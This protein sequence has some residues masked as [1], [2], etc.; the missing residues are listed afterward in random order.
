MHRIL[1]LLIC[2]LAI[3]SVRVEAQIDLLPL[4]TNSQV[5]AFL[6]RNPG[7]VWNKENSLYKW[8]QRDT[9]KIPFFD[10]FTSTTIYPDSSKWLDNQVFV[11][12]DF[13]IN[14]PSYGV[15]TFDFLT[16]EGVPYSPLED[17]EMM[18]ADSLTSQPINLKDSA[19]SSYG[20]ADSFFFS[21]Y[22][23]TRGYGD[24]ITEDDSLRLEFLDA[25]GDWN[26]VWSKGGD[27]IQPFRQVIFPLVDL[28]YYHQAFQFRFVNITHLWGNNNHWHLDYIYL[29]N[30][31][32]VGDT[33]FDDYAIQSRPTSLLKS[34][35]SM[36]Y[37]HFLADPSEAADSIFFNVSNRND[38]VI[39]AQIKHEEKHKGNTLVST[40]FS[41]N[42][43]N[44][45]NGGYAQRK[46]KNYDF[47]GL[48]GLPVIID[49]KYSIME[50]GRVNPVLFQGNDNIEVQQ[51][52]ERYYAYDDG[53]AESGF[54]FNDLRNGEGQIAISFDLKKS[55]SLQAIAMNLTYNINDLSKQ[56]FILTIWQDLGLGGG[57]PVILYEQQLVTDSLHLNPSINGYYLIG[58]TSPIYLSTGKFYVGWSQDRNY[59]LGVGFDK[60]NGYLPGSRTMNKNIYF[61]IGDGWVQNNNSSL[62]GAPMIRPIF[63]VKEPWNVGIKE[64]RNEV[65][66]VFPNPASSKLFISQEFF[67]YKVY[68]AQGQ[69]VE[70][71]INGPSE[72]DISSLANGVYIITMEFI[73]GHT[74]ALRFV[75]SN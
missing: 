15:A 36:P 49:R 31:R 41:D 30:H 19:G 12:T 28:S 48:S 20:P 47:S 58:L 54:G 38:I 62:V 26:L 56:R 50:S 52:F 59:N 46:V 22:Y 44:V 66:S 57:E 68:N 23:Q 72:L 18:G 21:F 7:Y 10:D 67:N 74:S 37:D 13:P 25:N 45:P 51:V 33:T 17:L 1:L 27:L 32:S 6:D 53:T 11:N 14:P 16:D 73:N 70:V 43:A 24:L 42:V 71:N 40:S 4:R 35:F 8:G 69:Q 34:Y 60:N 64:L 55:D 39:N 3:T 2:L 9:L 75:K 63:G 61:N 65:V 29:N 5:K